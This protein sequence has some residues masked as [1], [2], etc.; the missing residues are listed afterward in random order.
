[1]KRALML[2]ALVVVL[3]GAALGQRT[4]A[5]FGFTVSTGTP[6]YAPW[7]PRPYVPAY[8]VVYGP[9]YPVVAP[10]YCGPNCRYRYWQRRERM[11]RRWFRRHE[12]CERGYWR[13]RGRWR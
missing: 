9:V 10:P 3:A 2:V 13:N 5:T 11:E 1:M 7:Y 12:L 4:S 8:P 6:A